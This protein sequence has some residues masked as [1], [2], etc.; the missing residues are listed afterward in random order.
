MKLI[1]ESKE[2]IKEDIIYYVECRVKSLINKKPNNY[3]G[4]LSMC[5]RNLDFLMD[6]IIKKMKPK[7][8]IVEIYLK[9]SVETGK[10]CIKKID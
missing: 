2:L 9:V 5:F 1:I 10:T 3:E 8:V 6:R 7:E 4:S